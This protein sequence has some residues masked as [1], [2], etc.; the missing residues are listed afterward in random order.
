MVCSL[1]KS[2]SCQ[3][4]Y[5][6]IEFIVGNKNPENITI[7]N[8]TATDAIL[9]TSKVKNKWFDGGDYKINKFD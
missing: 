5:E 2:E 7:N 9:E 3:D 4:D 1:E 8:Q 6:N